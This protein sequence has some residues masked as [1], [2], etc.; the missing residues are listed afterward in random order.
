[1]SAFVLLFKL[2]FAHY[3]GDF[4]LQNEYIAMGKNAIKPLKGTPFY[5]PLFAHAMIH[6]GLVFLATES[7]VIGAAETLVHYVID[8]SKSRQRGPFGTLSPER[9]YDLDQ[10]LHILCK[11]IW[12]SIVLIVPAGTLP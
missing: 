11:L 9:S 1:M 4:A 6:G 7:A 5:H 2:V 12:L 8:D 3:V 10:A